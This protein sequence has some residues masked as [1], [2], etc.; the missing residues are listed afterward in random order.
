MDLAKYIGG[1]ENGF[2]HIENIIFTYSV[3]HLFLNRMQFL[4]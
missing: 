4:Y 2:L 1:N 3:W